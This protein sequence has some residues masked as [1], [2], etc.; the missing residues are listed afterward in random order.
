VMPAIGDAFV[1]EIGRPD[2]AG[3]GVL[4]E[5]AAVQR[6]PAGV[7]STERRPT[8]EAIGPRWS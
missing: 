4:D 2:L 3:H 8:A 5:L 7:R 6:P 1:E